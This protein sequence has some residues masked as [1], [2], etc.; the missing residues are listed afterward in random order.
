MVNTVEIYSMANKKFRQP[1]CKQVL[2]DLFS[3]K[4]NTEQV[5]HLYSERIGIF[6]LQYPT[7]FFIATHVKCKNFFM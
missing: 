3:K 2:R 4:V 1:E 7:S 5:L 6:I